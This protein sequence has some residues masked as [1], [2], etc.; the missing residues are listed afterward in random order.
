MEQTFETQIGGKQ[1]KLLV[2]KLAPAAHAAVTAQYGDTVVLATVV[3]NKTARE[4]IDYFPLL[5]D[6]EERLYAA[7]KIKGSRFIK[8]E[9]RPT[10]EAVLAARMIDRS[11][12]PLF[13]GHVRNDVQVILTILS[14]DGENDPDIPSLI[15]TSAALAISPIPW[16]GPIGGIRIGRINGE[17]VINPTYEARSKSTL[18]LVVATREDRILMVE[19]QASE[20]PETTVLAGMEFG[21]KHAHAVTKLIREMVEKIGAAKLEMPKEEN[22]LAEDTVAIGAKEW[23]ASR[24]PETLFARTLP[25]KKNRKSVIDDLRREL[26]ERLVADS[27]GK[28]KRR[29]ILDC[30]DEW[31]E[32]AVTRAILEREQRVD[33]RGLSDIRPLTSEVAILPRTHGSGLFSRGETQVLSVATLGAPS[34][35]QTMESIE[36]DSKKR[37]MHHYNFPPYSVAE[38]APLRGA[39]R[40]EIGHGA[41]AEKAIVPV[42]PPKDQFPYAIRVVSEVLSSDGSSSMASS[43]GSTLALM[44]AGVPI[45]APV[46]GVAM[47]LASD[48]NG[49]YK[50]LT[51]LQDLEDGKG[52]MDFKIAGTRK[53]ITAI[54]MDTKTTGLS[55]RQVEETL[56]RGKQARMT[57]LDQMEKTLPSPRLELS[58][59]APKI[60]TI[61]INPEKIRDVIGPGGKVIHEITDKTGATIDIEE[62]GLIFA[63]AVNLEAAQ[64]AIEWIKNITHEI[65]VGEVFTG[66][67]TRL[68]DFGAFV[69]VLPKQ[70]GLVHISELEHRRVERVSD[71]LNIGDTVQVKVVGIDDLGRINLSRKALLPFPVQSAPQTG[72]TPRPPR[73]DYN[74]RRG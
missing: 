65:A 13:P 33:G 8:R 47:G 24:L 52:G 25:T 22:G 6:Y 48:G 14:V 18:D 50:I 11:I 44:D 2:G 10:D 32:Q 46:A 17:W 41:L 69:E 39:G 43:C 27:V 9:T 38:V 34:L 5:V 1:L 16:N 45:T 29:E 61:Q 60:L 66:K 30:M 70:E 68:M 59:Y 12:R 15:A 37:Y 57:I 53:G 42:L 19:T 71:V 56:E 31:I 49:N 3:M 21:L 62:S 26:E 20:E 36:G 23:L 35:E 55:I 72:Y 51:D 64:K 63:T 67:V 73:R 54:Q 58:P 74:G 28:D 40:R 7:G 4:G